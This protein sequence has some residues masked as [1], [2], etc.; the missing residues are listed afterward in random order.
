MKFSS[1]PFALTI[2][3]ATFLTGCGESDSKPNTLQ[4]SEK[5]A[6]NNAG[7]VIAPTGD[8]ERW[9]ISALSS[10]KVI[11]K[12]K[13]E[14]QP[15]YNKIH[16]YDPM[17]FGENWIYDMA[18]IASKNESFRR[19][20]QGYTDM[21]KKDL[22]ELLV[23]VPQNSTR[24]G[25]S[26]NAFKDVLSTIAVNDDKYRLLSAQFEASARNQSIPHSVSPKNISNPSFLGYTTKQGQPPSVIERVLTIAALQLLSDN[27]AGSYKTQIAHL[28]NNQAVT[29]CLTKAKFNSLQCSAASYDNKDLS[30]C[31]A[32]HSIGEV[33]SCMSWL[34]P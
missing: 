31:A 10:Q 13:N 27:G 24:F 4:M 23:K 5:K 26:A 8:Y 14:M 30:F 20:V 7:V 29:N 11:G 9:H 25:G 3:L 6:N 16:D 22:A 33:S 1:S 34:L 17:L 32:K 18:Q 28:A 19:S 15:A 2:I 12:S 21:S